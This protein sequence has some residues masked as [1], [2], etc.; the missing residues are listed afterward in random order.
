LAFP[1]D[2]AGRIIR[3]HQGKE[4]DLEHNHSRDR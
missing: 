1:G 2:F 4:H 3:A